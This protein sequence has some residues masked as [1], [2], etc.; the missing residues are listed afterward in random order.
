MLAN[1]IE[2]AAALTN[3]EP[4]ILALHP[5]QLRER[6]QEYCDPCLRVRTKSA[7]KH[8]NA[9]HDLWPLS[10][11]DNRPRRRSAAEQ[12]DKI[13][14]P[15]GLSPRQRKGHGSSI[16]GQGR[17]SQQK[18]PLMSA[19]GHFRQIGTLPTLSTCPLR[20]KSGQ[21]NA[22]LDMSACTTRIG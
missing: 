12:R 6:L 17:A 15:H 21:A 9:P 8:P 5:A 3:F 14:P 18:G 7:C 13:T 1:D 22:C 2:I 19:L 4:H 10:L 16:A 11:R 20:S